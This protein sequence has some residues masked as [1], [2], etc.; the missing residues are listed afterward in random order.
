M[1]KILFTA[2]AATFL[3]AGCQKTEIINSSNP[4]GKQAMFFSTE[5]GKITKAEETTSPSDGEQ[6]LQKQGFKLSAKYAFEDI[7]TTGT[8]QIEFNSYYDELAN[9]AFQYNKT[10][11]KYEIVP[12]QNYFWPGTGK[13][14]VFFAISTKQN[15]GKDDNGVDLPEVLIPN[16]T[17]TGEPDDN[18]KCESI[19]IE[20]FKIENY[21]V[22]APKYVTEGENIGDQTGAD[23]D[24]MIAEVVI[25]NQH[26][27]G[28]VVDLAFNHTLSKV[29]FVF[30]TNPE[31]AEEYPVTVKSVTV[32]DVVIKADLEVGVT[33]FTPAIKN[34]EGGET[35]AVRTSNNTYDWSPA[36]AAH[37]YVVAAADDAKA[38]YIINYEMN[39][40][41]VEGGQPYA[42]W[43]VIPQTLTNKK[44]YVTYTIGDGEGA[45]KQVTSVW[46]LSG[47]DNQISAWQRNQYIKYTI[48]LSPNLI[49]FNP[50]IENEWNSVQ[51]VEHSN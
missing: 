5:I 30:T 39:L 28:G 37:E 19:E 22:K 2:L 42:T 11:N 1:K 48:N 25:R 40:T 32:K 27:N 18:G 3:A 35:P 49:T 34:A 23:D 26:E 4:T 45:P 8:D 7:Y 41:G 20:N 44:V 43:L 46:P 47:I 9:V 50:S 6:K 51:E 15:G 36:E 16:V 17:L 29:E 14:L 12:N 21:T 13:D 10:N 38:D 31:T 24:L 33:K